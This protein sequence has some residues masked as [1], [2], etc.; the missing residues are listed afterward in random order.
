MLVLFNEKCYSTVVSRNVLKDLIYF[1]IT[2]LNDKVLERFGQPDCPI[3]CVNL[4]LL[5]VITNTN[6]TNSFGACIRLLQEVTNPSQI[7]VHFLTPI[8]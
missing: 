2:V 3:K 5:R 6:K 7:I 8:F 4:L 1:F